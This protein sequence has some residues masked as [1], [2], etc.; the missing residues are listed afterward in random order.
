MQTIP[1]ASQGS[2][3]QSIKAVPLHKRID[4]IF[5]VTTWSDG[6]K[7]FSVGGNNIIQKPLRTG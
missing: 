6:R 7:T 5:T 1:D 3:Q 2:Q 4:G